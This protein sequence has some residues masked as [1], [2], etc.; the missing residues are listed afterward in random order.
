MSGHAALMAKRR[1]MLPTTGQGGIAFKHC[2]VCHRRVLS[3]YRGEVTAVGKSEIQS[4][5]ANGDVI[6]LCECG[7]RAVWEREVSRQR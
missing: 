6:G 3:A 2:R 4:V 5:A 1:E 7:A